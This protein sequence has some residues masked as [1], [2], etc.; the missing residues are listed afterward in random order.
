MSKPEP[1]RPLVPAF[2]I[3]ISGTALPLSTAA[4]VA[5][6]VVS[7]DM[8][9]PGM[10]NFELTGSDDQ[11]K[12]VPWIDDAVFSLGNTV[13][14]KLGYGDKLDTLFKGEIVGIEPSYSA[15]RLPRL[16][17]RCFDRLHRL[18]RGRKSRTYA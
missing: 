11:R 17:V 12:A 6:V 8:D 18:T 14:V 10:C 5:N 2:T 13:E 15:D 16:Q 7:Q 3:A 9:M 1:K 4:H